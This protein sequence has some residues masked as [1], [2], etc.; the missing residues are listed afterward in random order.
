[1]HASTHRTY[2]KS[3]HIHIEETDRKTDR[4]SGMKTGRQADSQICR[5]TEWTV[6]SSWLPASLCVSPLTVVKALDW[7]CCSGLTDWCNLTPIYIGFPRLVSQ[8]VIK[9]LLEGVLYQWRMQ[10]LLMKRCFTEGR[11]GWKALFLSLLFLCSLSF[12]H[13]HYL[14]RSHSLL[15]FLSLEH[16]CTDIYPDKCNSIAIA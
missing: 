2:L 7:A 14:S 15:C 6:T 5:Q 3:H 4:Q 8:C 10:Y 16:I 13:S 9:W 12:S 11:G 1:M